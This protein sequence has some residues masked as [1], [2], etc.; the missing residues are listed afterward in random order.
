MNASWL[1]WVRGIVGIQV[2]GEKMETLVNRALEK[3]IHLWSIS[4][5]SKGELVCFVTVQDF[6]RLRPLLKETNCRL[7][8]I[9]RQGMP[10]WFERLEKRIFFG[11][12]LAL[13][14]VGMYLLSSLVWSIEV[15]GN[16]L[17]SEEQ[18]LRAAQQEGVFPF[19]W[20]F[21]LSDT[22]VISKR[23]TQKLPG[24]AW[25]GVEK[26][27]TK[28]SIQV[29]ETTK[30]AEK[31]LL[32]PRHLVA[33]ADAVVTDIMAETG[34]PVVKRNAK[35]KKG[36]VLISGILGDE[37][38]TQTVVAQGE[39]K[40]LV[41]HE[42]NIESPLKRKMKG[43]TGEM[44]TRWYIVIGGRALK[45][46]GFGDI[47]YEQYEIERQLEEATWRTRSLPFGK[48]KETIREVQEGLTGV[49]A[50]E[51]KAAGLEQAKAD[52]LAKNGS[53]AK[54]HAENILHEKTENGKVYM[55]VLF[56]VEQSIV[57]ERPLVH[58]QGE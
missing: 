45:V 41:W 47:P 42:Y 55:K 19:Q 18:V 58:T 39:V 26:R 44:M 36:D 11:V 29:V 27:G 1:Q 43:Y 16:N 28:I 24:A 5:T 35:V 20:S 3:K 57:T 49:T 46:S 40:G 33:S 48:M 9:S 8:V 51:A 15:K 23:L 38:N 4:W 13:F 52:I 31:P 7:H 56:E 34:R 6:F 32:S 14:F 10:F 2:R 30:P 21:R 22:D 12:G 53:G 54:I 25:V 37:A 50:E 17:I